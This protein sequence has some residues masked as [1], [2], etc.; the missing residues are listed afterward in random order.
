[1][2]SVVSSQRIYSGLA[3][4][5]LRSCHEHFN[6]N[7]CDEHGQNTCWTSSS[8][9]APSY[10]QL[11]LTAYMRY[12]LDVIARC[13]PP[14]GITNPEYG[15]F[16]SAIC[17]QTDVSVLREGFRS[18]PSGHS[19]SALSSRLHLSFDDKCLHFFFQC[20]LLGLVS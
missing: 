13:L 12:S 8:W 9:Y 4:S 6:D 20:P 3:V 14:S 15:L 5:E 10:Y 17:T 7:V 1:M 2:L 16:S 18:F 11:R 19:S